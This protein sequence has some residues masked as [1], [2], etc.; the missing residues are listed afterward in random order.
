[1]NALK[2]I[3]NEIVQIGY[4]PAGI[5]RDYTF[6]DVM[7]PMGPQRSIALAA[8][9]QTPASYRTA[10]FGVVADDTPDIAQALMGYRALGA[11]IMLSISE[12]SIKVW[13]IR[14]KIEAKLIGEYTLDQIPALFRKESKQWSPESIHRAKSIGEIAPEYQLDFVD[15]GLLPAIEGEIHLKLD[16]LLKEVFSTLEDSGKSRNIKRID[17]RTLFQVTF[18][19]LAAKILLDREHKQALEWEPSDINS[20]FFG[21]A[22]YYSL[23]QI[24]P[25]K[26]IGAWEDFNSAWQQLRNA[27]SFRNISADD[28]A[29]VYENT[30]VTTETRK[31]FGTH[32]TPRQVAEYVVANLGLNQLPMQSL[33]VFEPFSGAGVFLVSAIRHIRDL[34]PNN[35]ND[36]QRHK[37]LT[38]RITGS[39]IDSFACEVS[40]LSLILADY[41]NANGWHI[42]TEDLFKDNA[43]AEK[44]RGSNVILCNP[45][46]EDFSIEERKRYKNISSRSVHKPVAVLE[47]ILDNAPDAIGFVLPKGFILEKQYGKIREKLEKNYSS[48]EVVSLPDRIF[49]VSA[50]ESSIFIAKEKRTA[51]RKSK[52]QLTSTTVNDAD[53]TLFL[54]TGMVTSK[55]HREKLF[56]EEKT[57]QLWVEELSD[58]WECL[59]T[60]PTLGEIANIHRGL[61]WNYTQSLAVSP[62]K[63]Q[64]FVR[65]LHSVAGKTIEQFRIS[66][67]A[68]LD[69]RKESLRTKAFD[70]PWGKPKIIANNVRLSRSPWRLAAFH[71]KEKLVCSQ[72]FIGIWPREGSNINLDALSAILNSPLANAFISINSPQERF[73]ISILKKLPLPRK[74]NED[75]ISKL[76][77]QYQETLALDSILFEYGRDNKLNELLIGID[78]EVLRA[79]DLPPRLEKSLLNHFRGYTRPVNHD[80]RGWFPEDF[81]PCIPL[82]EYIG[83]D[84]KKITGNWVQKVFTP[85]SSSAAKLLRDYMD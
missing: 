74:L 22:N 47:T 18:R 32:S 39:E 15:I 77:E 4:K 2:I 62:D 80:F 70:K 36:Q 69:T 65:G 85:L 52:V 67:Q 7:A 60:H 38:E 75:R 1:M 82:H 43:L 64:G 40:S 58:V 30:L 17:Y 42:S 79:Y 53:R 16:R 3:E 21:I 51:V 57:G 41:P 26:D 33:R 35:W 14:S 48:I 63:K 83:Q 5:I 46:F 50:I 76:V 71:D 11:P 20:T 27:I 8:F 68:Y 37:F 28:L 73:R 9:T 81:T 84:Y 72:Q 59:A 6:A 29:F 44:A 23:N 61:E 49:Q 31:T 25:D 19:L 45:P 54:K 10:A 78:A 66:N 34:L 12:N 13:K 24:Q 55:R 56:S